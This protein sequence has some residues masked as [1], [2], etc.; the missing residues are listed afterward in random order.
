V[1]KPS[2]GSDPSL[3]TSLYIFLF[4]II[5]DTE[6]VIWSL[7]SFSTADGTPRFSHVRFMVKGPKEGLKV[8]DGMNSFIF[9]SFSSHLWFQVL[10][11]L[12]KS[13]WPFF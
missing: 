6:K 13:E 10:V 9:L 8:T 5:L 3:F 2:F 1:G 12:I 4:G 11:V 7:F